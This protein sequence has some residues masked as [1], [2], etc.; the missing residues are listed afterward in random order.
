MD[1]S[2]SLCSMVAFVDTREALCWDYGVTTRLLARLLVS[3]FCFVDVMK[4]AASVVK[5][6]AKKPS[7]QAIW[8]TSGFPLSFFY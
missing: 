6:F 8:P 7:I 4:H 5:W 2:L 1:L 3:P